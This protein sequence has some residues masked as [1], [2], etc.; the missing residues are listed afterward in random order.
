MNTST[1][2]ATIDIFNIKSHYIYLPVLLI[3]MMISID[4]YFKFNAMPAKIT[5]KSYYGSAVL[6]VKICLISSSQFY[7]YHFARVK[8]L[9][10]DLR[11]RI[12][13]KTAKSS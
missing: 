8:A 2:R 12:E 3:R 10:N 13:I 1:R 7:S 6:L 9:I 4:N 5:I 11:H